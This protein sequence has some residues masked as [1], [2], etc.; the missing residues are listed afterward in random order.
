[1]QDKLTQKEIQTIKY[2]DLHAEEWIV[3]HK[4]IGDYGK[5]APEFKLLF[6]LLPNGKV[7]EIGTGTGEDAKNLIHQYGIDNYIGVEPARG[8]RKIAQENNPDAH[9]VDTTIYD[10]NF[11]KNS[12][13]GF[14]LCQ[15]LIHIPKDR[16][17]EAFNSLKKVVKKNG[18]GMISILE[19]NDDMQ[20]SRPGRYYSLWS[21]DEFSKILRDNNFEI[22]H[23]R[24]LETGASPWLI[25]I[26]KKT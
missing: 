4:Q 7:L 3:N 5:L 16:L 11:P 24:K 21:F 14:W 2:Y 8:L 18:V 13:D 26:I 20:E 1:M 10:L 25:F 17:T 12:F 9:F 22:L 6:K 19:G 15:M 23:S